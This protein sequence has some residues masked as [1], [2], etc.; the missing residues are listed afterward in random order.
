MDAAGTGHEVP[1]RLPSSERSYFGSFQRRILLALGL[2]AFVTL[3]AFLDRGGYRDAAGDEVSLLDAFYY[4]TVSIT[5]TGYGDVIPVTDRTRLITAV[6][7]TPAR[8]LF[9]ILLVGTT[10]EF[11]AERT[12]E[13]YRLRYWRARLKEHTII[14]GY[15]SKGR[16]AVE[17]I[18]GAGVERSAVV[19]I[20]S[21]ERALE[22]ARAAGL[23]VVVG[24]ATSTDVL[25]TAGIE[26]ARAVVVAANRDDASVLITLTARELNPTATIV[27]AVREE[28][29]AHLLRHGGADS[30][31]TSSGAAGR[32]LGLATQT[33]R[34]GRARGPDLGG[35]GTRHSRAAGV[36]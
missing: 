22:R 26:S 23:A 5:T 14:C 6:L 4:A 17:S 8:I 21:N 12:R 2:I 28:E 19:V 25:R 7:I 34:G 10:L 15:G 33:P 29:N 35:R 3:L 30:V 27:S 9:L 11:L 36:R 1:V 18:T 13:A 20:D 32:L 31:I 24:D 16:S